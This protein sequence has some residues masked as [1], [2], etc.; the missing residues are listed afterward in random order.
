MINPFPNLNG[1]TVEV[2]SFHPLLVMRLLIHA[3]VPE[4]IAV[5]ELYNVGH[6]VQAP[7]G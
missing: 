2:I 5:N 3:D 7:M 4:I 1:A 6:I